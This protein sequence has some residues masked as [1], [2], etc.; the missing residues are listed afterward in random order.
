VCK[1][2]DED[3]L[4]VRDCDTVFVNS[5]ALSMSKARWDAPQEQHCPA[6]PSKVTLL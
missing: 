3:S 5:E 6:L 4:R 1:H 2:V